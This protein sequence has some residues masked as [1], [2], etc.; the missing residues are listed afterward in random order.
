MVLIDDLQGVDGVAGRGDEMP[1]V[2]EYQS[3]SSR[4]LLAGKYVLRL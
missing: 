3:G 2:V 4:N 1:F